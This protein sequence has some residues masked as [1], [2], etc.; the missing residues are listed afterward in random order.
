MIKIDVYN[1]KTMRCL[2][3]GFFEGKMVKYI[4][5]YAYRK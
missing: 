5:V 3:R 2:Y 1:K 4:K